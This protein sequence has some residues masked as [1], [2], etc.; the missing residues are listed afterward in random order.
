MPGSR[1]YAGACIAH[2]RL[3]IHPFA[4]ASEVYNSELSMKWRHQSRQR[5]FTRM[6]DG[7]MHGG[8]A[9]LA[10]GPGI[11]DRNFWSR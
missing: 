11:Q 2:I 4:D 10:Q 9:H 3:S 7:G 5:G 6:Y 8:W 1:A